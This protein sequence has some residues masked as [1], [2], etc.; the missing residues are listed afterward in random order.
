MTLSEGDK[1]WIRIGLKAHGIK[2]TEGLKI[3]LAPNDD[4]SIDLVLIPNGV[5]VATYELEKG[6]TIEQLA[7]C[8]QDL[9]EGSDVR[10]PS[11]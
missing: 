8:L 6:E 4:G 5:S 2:S 9:F 10:A 11:A 7:E 3:A 1:R